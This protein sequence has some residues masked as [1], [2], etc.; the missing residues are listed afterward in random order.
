MLGAKP[1]TTPASSMKLDHSSTPLPDPASYR[2]TV[3]AFQ[4]LM[5]TRPDLAFAVTQ[6]CQFMHSPRTIHLQAV[7]RILR[8]LKGTI[9]SGL[10]FTKGKQVLTTLTD[11]D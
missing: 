11:A 7:K 5:W 10:W 3:G 2:S 9:D 4:Y 1:C 6:V 8:Y